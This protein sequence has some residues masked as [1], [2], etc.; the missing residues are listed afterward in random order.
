VAGV[1]F[2]GICTVIFVLFTSYRFYKLSLS[3]VATRSAMCFMQ[4]MKLN[5]AMIQQSGRFQ[6]R[7]GLSASVQQPLVTQSLL[8]LRLATFQP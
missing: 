4:S 5:W 1:Y 2:Y 3:A 7:V 6:S 8:G